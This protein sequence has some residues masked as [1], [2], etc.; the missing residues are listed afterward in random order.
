MTLEK[1]PISREQFLS[2]KSKQVSWEF[3]Q[4]EKKL[5]KSKANT[6]NLTVKSSNS[7]A[8]QTKAIVSTPKIH[9][10]L[11]NPSEHLLI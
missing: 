3:L 6:R 7:T 1:S 8:A 10:E 4:T 11:N 2:Q 5:N 9:T